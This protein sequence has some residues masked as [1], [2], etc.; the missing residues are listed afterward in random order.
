LILEQ[1]PSRGY[2]N[3]PNPARELGTTAPSGSAPRHVPVSPSPPSEPRWGGTGAGRVRV[4]HRD[5]DRVFSLKLG[6][7]LIA[8]VHLGLV[9][10]SEATH[11]F[12][13]ALGRVRHLS[14]SRGRRPGATPRCLVSEEAAGVE[15]RR[16]ARTERQ[17]LVTPC[18]PGQERPASWDS[19]RRQP[20]SPKAHFR[21]IMAALAAAPESLKL[22]SFSLA[23]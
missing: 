7:V 23:N 20:W 13:V 10:R 2:P 3:R 22:L 18:F 1:S 11:H 14:R 21:S 6:D 15:R 17:Q 4:T 19:K 12:D 9:E 5:H 8:A 16:V